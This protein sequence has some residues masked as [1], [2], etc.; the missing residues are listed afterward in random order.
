MLAGS[1]AAAGIAW[2]NSI[3]N[4]SGYAAPFLL[5]AVRDA[6]RD[7]AHPNGDMLLALS[8]LAVSLLT[9]GL[10]T[11]LVRGGSEEKTGGGVEEK[12]VQLRV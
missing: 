2:I 3:G 6:T 11:L 12:A 10:V 4:L 8:V 5:G 1:G 9:A 7:A